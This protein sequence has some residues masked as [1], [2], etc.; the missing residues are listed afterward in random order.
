MLTILFFAL[1]A[2]ILIFQLVPAT[3]MFIGL[4]RGLFSSKE[5]DV[6]SKLQ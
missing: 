4:M 2:I 5:E 3:I 1:M 6:W